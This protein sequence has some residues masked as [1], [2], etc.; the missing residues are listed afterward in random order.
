LL[1]AAGTLKATAFFDHAV[2]KA[3]SQPE[4]SVRASHD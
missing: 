2:Y 1:G 3:A 4:T